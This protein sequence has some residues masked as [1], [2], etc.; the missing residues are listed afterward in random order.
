MSLI[1]ISDWMSGPVI[2][3]KPQD[4]LLSAIKKMAKHNIGCLVI[5]D[6]SIK[7]HGIISERDILKK[8]V[9]KQKNLAK[10]RV[11]DI[12]TTKV[13]TAD[14]NSSLLY[15]IK[16]MEKGKFRDTPIMKKGKLAG[17]ITSQDVIRMLS[18]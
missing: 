12:M 13:K 8:A 10:L 6:K 16:M 18:I 11:V 9:A 2:C 1:K 5:K 15:L 4:S 7:I 17:I 3:A 14:I